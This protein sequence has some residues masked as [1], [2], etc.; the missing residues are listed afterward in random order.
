MSLF[1][2][3]TWGSEGFPNA[4][5]EAS[6]MELPVIAT[7]VVGCVDAVADGVTGTLVPPRDQSAL[8]EAVR[9]YL[10]NA[11]MRREQGVAGRTRVLRDFRQELIWKAVYTEYVR[12]LR[13]GV[14]DRTDMWPGPSEASTH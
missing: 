4:L 7:R 2:F 13:H 5:M 14:S 1:V 3:P 9:A 6:C 12:L 10:G 8:T 11:T